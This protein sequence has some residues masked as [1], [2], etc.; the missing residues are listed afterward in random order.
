IN[1]ASRLF[2]VN[3]GGGGILDVGCYPVSA[4]RLFAGAV[5]GRPYLDPVKVTALGQL[6]ETGVDDWTAAVL[7]FE[8]GVVAQVS[9][10]IRLP[11]DN[12]FRILGSEGNIFIPN[13]WLPSRDGKK[14]SIFLTKKGKGTEE[15]DIA[16]PL[17][18][19]DITLYGYEVDA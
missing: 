10:A 6:G 18:E 4:A 3:L 12:N 1:P 15:I 11:L 2:D 16:P 7:Q 14:V 9:T 5:S 19:N 17:G 13:P 8:N